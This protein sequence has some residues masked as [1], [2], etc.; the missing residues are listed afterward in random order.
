MQRFFVTGPLQ[1][2]GQLVTLP[3]DAAR[4]VVTVLRAREGDQIRLFNHSGPEWLTSVTQITRDRVSVQ[5]IE[6][7]TSRPVPA[8]S[9]TLCTALLKGDKLEWVLQKG[10]E[11]GVFAFQPMLTER[12][13]AR[14]ID[15]PE[16]WERIVVEAAELC[17]RVTIPK[18]E[19][20][21]T[22]AEALRYQGAKL[23]CYEDEHTLAFTEALAGLPGSGLAVFVGPEGGFAERE[24]EEARAAGALVTSLGSLLLR[25]ETAAIAASTLALLG[26]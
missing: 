23:L 25:A 16:R 21:V 18:I 10:T 3:P 6:V 2:A 13:V 26:P 20:P 5:L 15:T 4:Q 14:K 24:V 19:V 11:L 9:F 8:R 17:G 7:V 22:L 12:V 1:R